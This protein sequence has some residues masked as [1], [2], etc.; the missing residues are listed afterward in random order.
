MQSA[1]KIFNKKIKTDCSFFINFMVVLMILIILKMIKIN[2]T[3]I[4]R[5]LTF[6]EYTN[7]LQ[8]WSSKTMILGPRSLIFGPQKAQFFTIFTSNFRFQ[9]AGIRSYQD[10]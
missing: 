7:T 8:M 5:K 3:T 10:E 9:G 1:A 6:F 2:K 4:V